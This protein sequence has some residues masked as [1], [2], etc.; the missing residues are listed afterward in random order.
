MDVDLV[1][2]NAAIVMK[3]FLVP[4]I[5]RFRRK[6]LHAV[7]ARISAITWRELAASAGFVCW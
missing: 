7:S 5:P 4:S 6:Y 3:V 1:I 2:R